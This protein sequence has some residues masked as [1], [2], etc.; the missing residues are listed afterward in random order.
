M[1]I[2]LRHGSELPTDQ[3]VG[4]YR[5]VGWS[6]Y[7]DDPDALKRAVS[8]SSHVVTA[9]EIDQLVGLARCVSDD[10]S[11]AYLQD[12]LVTPSHQRRGIGRQLIDDCL[13]RFA[14]VRQKVLL[15][16]DRPEQ[17]R[18]YGHLGF[19]NTRKLETTRLN[20]FV[21]I[22]GTELG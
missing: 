19:V 6:H 15:T 21:R 18:F 14:H 11:I 17:L 16:D 10:V 13:A 4:L 2:E 5:S 3:L 9:W 8:G 12:I 1:P 20:A 22:E 7:A